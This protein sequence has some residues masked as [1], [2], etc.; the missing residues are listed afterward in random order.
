ME[1]LTNKN[2]I[3]SIKNHYKKQVLLGICVRSEYLH[4]EEVIVKD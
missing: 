1:D 3:K 2:L 4:S